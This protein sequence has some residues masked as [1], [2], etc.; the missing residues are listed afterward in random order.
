M[1]LNK[2]PAVFVTPYLAVFTE[3]LYQLKRLDFPVDG[4]AKEVMEFNHS[5]S[6]F[7]SDSNNAV[8]IALSLK[9]TNMA[10]EP[11]H[12]NDF[13]KIIAKPM[14]DYAGRLESALKD[15]NLHI[16]EILHKIRVFTLAF[17]NQPATPAYLSDALRKLSETDLQGAMLFSSVLLREKVSDNERNTYTKIFAK[18]VELT[19]FDDNVRQKISD[20]VDQ[21]ADQYIAEKVND[22][23]KANPSG[24]RGKFNRL[25]VISNH[26]E[27][28][29]DN[30]RSA[31][32]V[33]RE[34]DKWID[35]LLEED[36][37][38]CLAC[39]YRL[40]AISIKY[41][42]CYFPN[43]DF[44]PH[45]SLNPYIKKAILNL[46]ISD[47]VANND[48]IKTQLFDLEL[49]KKTIKYALSDKTL[50]DL[51]QR[52]TATILENNSDKPIPFQ[53]GMG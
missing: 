28:L 44:D 10:R 11:Q 45:K 48:A 23:E 30:P 6:D 12:E 46:N 41:K 9:Y 32:A 49:I 26:Q 15:E 31:H 38:F 52:Y 40:K 21:I 53:Y 2:I 35:D 1:D 16:P 33:I 39:L 47:S 17:Q 24:F 27:D 37:V 19:I 29:F 3:L 20:T 5:L 14:A 13:L 7:N 51:T 42:D 34:V 4:L 43:D 18:N 36:P 50:D 22:F 25:A 8:L